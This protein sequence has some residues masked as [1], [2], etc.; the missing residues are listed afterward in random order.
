VKVGDKIIWYFDLT[1]KGEKR[2][3]TI[4]AI[5]PRRDG[6]LVF[7]DEHHKLEDCIY[8][9]Y[10]WPASVEAELDAILAR[11]RALLKAYDDSMKD[12]FE[13]R[14]AIARGERNG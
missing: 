4:T 7:V 3:G 5:K 14:N 8:A 6:D 2:S 1:G 12:V 10:C 13:L 9:A 11:R